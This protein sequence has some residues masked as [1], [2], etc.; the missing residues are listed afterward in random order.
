[1]APRAPFFPDT[2]GDPSVT[3][4][5]GPNETVASMTTE[6]FLCPSDRNWCASPWD[7]EAG[8]FPKYPPDANSGMTWLEGN[9]SWTRYNHLLPPGFNSCANRLTWNGIAMTTSSQHPGVV[10]LLLGDG[11]VRWYFLPC[12]CLGAKCDDAARQSLSPRRAR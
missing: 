2:T 9:M 11:S 7:Q 12:S 8:A 1:V 10:C 3:T 6:V 5:V 4:G